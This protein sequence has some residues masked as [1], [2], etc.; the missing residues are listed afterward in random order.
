MQRGST[1]AALRTIGA[2][3]M[4][5]RRARF[6]PTSRTRLRKMATRLTSYRSGRT[7]SITAWKESCHSPRVKK[8]LL[9]ISLS[10]TCL[11]CWTRKKPQRAC[12]SMPL[13][14][15][16]S[17]TTRT[18]RR[19]FS[20]MKASPDSP[21]LLATKPRIFETPDPALKEKFR[22]QVKAGQAQT[23]ELLSGQKSMGS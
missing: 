5:W 13:E 19:T 1:R 2:L 6:L 17:L 10:I 12:D 11:T 3:H 22:A 14:T 16:T 7:I 9:L 20:A 8:E 21:K 23:R 18:A 4:S 15:E